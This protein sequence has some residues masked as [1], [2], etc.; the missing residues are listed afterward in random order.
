M[1]DSRPP[2]PPS[3]HTAP[4]VL[5]NLNMIPTYPRPIRP[6]Y[7]EI[8]WDDSTLGAKEIIRNVLSAIFSTFKKLKTI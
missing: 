6:L 5:I 2:C 3:P 8:A 7:F 1:Y 4:C